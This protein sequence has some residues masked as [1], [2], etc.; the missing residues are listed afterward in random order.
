VHLDDHRAFVTVD[1]GDAL[2]D[3]EATAAQWRDA[4]SISEAPLDLTDVD[5]VLIS[6]MG[7]SGI[8]GD[9]LWALGLHRFERPII[10]HKGYGVPAFTGRRT[11][12]IAF[13][14]SGST[15]ETLSAF[16][17]AGERGAQRFAV[18]SGGPLAEACDA[19]GTPVAAIPPGGA[20]PPRHS[21]GYLLV[22]ALIALGLGDGIDEAIEV[23]EEVAAEQGR[24]VETAANPA[25]A[26]AAR[27]ATGVVPLTWGGHGLG[28][29]AAYRLKCQLNENAK[30]PA[31][32]AEL[33]EADHNDVVGWEEPSAL[34]GIGALIGL[35][36][37][38]GEHPRVQRRFAVTLD[39]LASRIAWSVDITARGSAPVA[40]LAALLLQADLVSVYT[41]LAA[42]RD[43][44]PIASIDRLKDELSTPLTVKQ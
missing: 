17:E 19:A 29:V 16:A 33:P 13:S 34:S 24:A 9:V 39:L 41:A 20:R 43:P 21:L 7:G 1:P 42:D 35:R 32:H 28:S 25:K 36:D 30:L 15:E 23:L 38:A 11:L 18:T 40:R 2:G 44:S 6:G 8:A 27:L 26:L 5:H 4:R 14:Y 3:V 22:P 12:L 37:T 31:L 10:V